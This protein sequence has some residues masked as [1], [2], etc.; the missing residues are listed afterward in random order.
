MS[1][2][3]KNKEFEKWIEEWMSKVRETGNVLAN[4]PTDNT[5]ITAQSDS[6]ASGQRQEIPAAPDFMAISQLKRELDFLD[7]GGYRTGTWWFPLRY[8]ED[9]PICKRVGGESCYSCPLLR[10]APTDMRNQPAP[11]RYITLNED[12][13]TLNN[14]YVTGTNQ[15]IESVVR[16]W[17]VSTLGNGTTA[18]SEGN[19]PEAA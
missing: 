18:P 2:R 16:S 6:G 5:G 8:F 3:G 14:L 15:E 4:I 17:L 19:K 1:A 7:S 9:S 10:F 12:G 13:E 11:C